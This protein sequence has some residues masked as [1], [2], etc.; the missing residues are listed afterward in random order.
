V[1]EC[2]GIPAEVIARICKVDVKTARRWKNGTNRVPETAKMVLV[3]D[4]GA[5]SPAFAGWTLRGGNLVSPEGW[6][7]TPG[8]ILSIPLL[9]AQVAAYQ[10][11]ERVVN[12]IEEQPLP[13]SAA[14]DIVQ[15]DFGTRHR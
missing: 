5:F 12:G 10:A 1:N 9:R 15:S 3:A 13:G 11:R 2:Y 8:D 14:M 6:L 4:L 7:A